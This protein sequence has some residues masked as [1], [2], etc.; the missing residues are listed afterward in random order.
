MENAFGRIGA[1]MEFIG[2][3]DGD[4]MDVNLHAG[5]QM[6]ADGERRRGKE[7]SRRRD[8]R[9]QKKCERRLLMAV[10]ALREYALKRAGI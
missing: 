7:T 4:Q 10:F 9:L 6:G 8:Q 3:G 2:A 1:G 5:L